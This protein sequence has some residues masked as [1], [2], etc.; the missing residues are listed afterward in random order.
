[1]AFCASKI[2]RANRGGMMAIVSM[3]AQYGG[4]IFALAAA[5]LWLASARVKTPADFPIAVDTT[6]S[7]WDGSVGGVG[8]STALQ[9]LGEALRRQSQLSACADLRRRLRVVRRAG[10]E[11]GLRSRGL[12]LRLAAS[13]AREASSDISRAGTALKTGAPNTKIAQVFLLLTRRA[14]NRF[15]GRADDAGARKAA[16]Q[17]LRRAR[18]PPPRECARRATLWL[19]Q[20]PR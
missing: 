15:P 9:E 18:L 3:L 8:S 1:M 5:G 16:P 2:F 7:T 17:D 10:A 12:C 13:C 20:I 19:S 14:P 11:L 4:A 6:M